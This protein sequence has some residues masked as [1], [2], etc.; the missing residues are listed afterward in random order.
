MCLSSEGLS[1]HKRRLWESHRLLGPP[2]LQV[3]PE[4]FG[5]KNS[6]NKLSG[7]SLVIV[8]DVPKSYSNSVGS[9]LV[10][11]EVC[12]F[13]ATGILGAWI[14]LPND[15]HVYLLSTFILWVRTNYKPTDYSSWRRKEKKW[16]GLLTWKLMSLIY[17]N[18]VQLN[19]IVLWITFICCRL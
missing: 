4:E 8:P 12:I 10:D 11:Q 9:I 14:I 18:H 2:L 13:A 1:H 3:W 16:T 19:T 15:I 5:G 17:L 7:R 6:G